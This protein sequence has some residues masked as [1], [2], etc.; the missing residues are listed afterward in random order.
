MNKIPNGFCQ[1]GCGRRTKL[2][3]QNHTK[4]GWKKGEPR[5]FICGHHTKTSKYDSANTNWKG[6]MVGINALHRWVERR[7]GRPRKCEKCG[8]TKAKVYHWAN[9]SGEYKRDLSDWKRLCVYCH[10]IFDGKIG[11]GNPNAKLTEVDVIDIR[12]L[13][14]TGKFTQRHL[15]KTF[16]VHPLTIGKIIRRETWK[17]IKP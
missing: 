12:K 11:E 2:N 8:T 16:S 4:N 1:C 14:S 15:S 13:Y 3:I 10:R 9:I 17:H 5:K 7:L 6:D